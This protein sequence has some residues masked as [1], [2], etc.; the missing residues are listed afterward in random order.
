MTHAPILA[1]DIFGTVVDWHGSIQREVAALHPQVDAD[2][3][4]LAWRAGYQPAMQRVRS[5]E[6]G[7]TLIDDLHRLI[8]DELL[9]TFG[10]N[11]LT[12]AQKQH[13]N[14]VWHRLDPWPDT[15]AGLTRLKT[16]QHGQTRGPAVGLRALGRG[17]SR[18]QTRPRHLPGCGPRV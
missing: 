18:L 1:F 12:E 5:G 17:V 10:L 11:A 3:F 13:L 8:L 2:A 7:W 6:L 4:A 9:P 15:V 14:K 16:R